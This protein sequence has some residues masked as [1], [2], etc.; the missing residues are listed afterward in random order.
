[1]FRLAGSSDNLGNGFGFIETTIRMIV[2]FGHKTQLAFH[3]I[4]LEPSRGG[5]GLNLIFSPWVSDKHHNKVR[6]LG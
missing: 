5:V 2:K 1:M 3:P 6:D 4:L